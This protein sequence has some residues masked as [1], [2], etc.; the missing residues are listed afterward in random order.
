MGTSANNSHHAPRDYA[1]NPMN[2]YWEM[3]QAC[4]LACRHCRAE[5]IS[6]PHPDQLTTAQSMDF[7]QQ[8]TSFASKPPR[9]PTGG[10]PL[11]RTDLYEIID[12]AVRLGLTVSVT[13]AATADLTV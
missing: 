10:D 4:G 8:L 2:L 7:L 1:K 11:E 9:I 5:A 13:P 12:E 6:T 3:T